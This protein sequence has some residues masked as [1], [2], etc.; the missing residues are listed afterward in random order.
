MMLGA[1][2]ASGELY[3]GTINSLSTIYR[4]EGGMARSSRAWALV[5]D[6]SRSAVSSSS[7]RTRRRRTSCGR[8]AD[9]GRNPRCSGCIALQAPQITVLALAIHAITLSGL[10]E[11]S[12]EILAASKVQLALGVMR[13][14]LEHSHA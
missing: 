6:G 2:N 13:L 12:S 9:G 7:E 11:S 4:E 10:A 8:P 1:K 14:R 5:W 3:E